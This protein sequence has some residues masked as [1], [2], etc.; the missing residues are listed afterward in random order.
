MI[1]ELRPVHL[2]CR[3]E[4]LPRHGVHHRAEP[5]PVPEGEAERAE[6]EADL[7]SRLQQSEGS[8]VPACWAVRGV[9]AV[10]WAW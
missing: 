8:G 1:V 6:R 10:V 5:E 9:K 7:L 4:K 3:G 2:V